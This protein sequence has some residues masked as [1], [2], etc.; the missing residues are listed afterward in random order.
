MTTP[1]L[2]ERFWEK[3]SKDD[4]DC[5]LWT[6]AL[7]SRGYGCWAI[8]G[9]SQLTHRVAY[10]AL[11]GPIPEGLTI[12]HLCRVKVCCNPAHLEP[13]SI[14][15]N[16]R[17]WAVLVTVCPAGHEYT[18]ENTYRNGAGRRSCR[19]CANAKRRKHPVGEGRR[20]GAALRRQRERE[21]RLA[22]CEAWVTA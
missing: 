9:R 6:G 14:A 5:W 4:T 19:E 11:V 20:I 15:E 10:A 1:V 8:N 13:V 2:T 17:R 21:R 3:V 22:A 16:T 7:N 12:D 18:L